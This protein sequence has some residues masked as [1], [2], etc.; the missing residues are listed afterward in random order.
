MSP[1]VRAL[2]GGASAIAGLAILAAGR[3]NRGRPVGGLTGFWHTVSATLGRLGEGIEGDGLVTQFLPRRI[4]AAMFLLFAGACLIS[5]L[6]GPVARSATGAVDGYVSLFT[7]QQ[8]ADAWLERWGAVLCTAALAVSGLWGGWRSVR[9]GEW[10]VAA[11]C[12]APP[13][14]RF[15]SSD[16]PSSRSS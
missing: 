2:L 9:R 14:L 13:G 16:L 12:G 10:V 8:E 15:R 6:D 11:L 1:L 7:R 4:L 3:E 5:L